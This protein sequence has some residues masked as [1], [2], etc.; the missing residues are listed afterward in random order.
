MMKACLA[1][2]LCSS[3][4]Y[5]CKGQLGCGCDYYRCKKSLDDKTWEIVGRT[6]FLMI[7]RGTTFVASS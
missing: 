3:I 2:Y 1:N 7:G 6:R 5:L 4:V